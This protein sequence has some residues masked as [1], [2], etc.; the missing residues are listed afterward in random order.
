VLWP[1]T[2]ANGIAP[3][4][5]GSMGT[6]HETPVGIPAGTIVVGADGSDHADRAIA[7]A[8]EEALHR[9]RQLTVVHVEQTIGS[10]E[11]GWL[12]QAGIP[13]SQV[14]EELRTNTTDILHRART[15]ATT[16]AAP[17][18]TDVFRYVGDPRAVLL[19]LAER[20]DMIVLGSRGRGP[21]SSLV[22]GSVSVAVSGHASCPVVV[23]RPRQDLARLRGVLVATDGTSRSAAT[24]ECA[25][26]EASHRTLPLTVVH[27]QWEALSGPGGWR[28]ARPDDPFWDTARIRIAEVIAGL[29]EK[30]PEVSVKRGIF[31]G[32][33]DQCVADLSREHDL[34]VIGR[35]QHTLL[36]RVGSFPLTTAI[37]EHACGPVLIVP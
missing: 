24:L 7:W 37:V 25:F 8:A 1:T 31:A 18:E 32:H 16:V 21:V 26:R 19:D 4:E 30:F 12:A 22:L 27:C 17:I 33:V 2:V 34:T 9:H 10:Q 28:A 35:H 3:A 36:E 20:A 14:S 6:T 5:P 11:R 23:V 15:L 13:L 29:R